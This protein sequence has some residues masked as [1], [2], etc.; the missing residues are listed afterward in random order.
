MI[1]KLS[2]TQRA[3]LLK[4][5]DGKEQ[6]ASRLKAGLGTL[7]S[8]ERRGMVVSR[9]PPGSMTY[10]HIYIHW[11]VTDTGRAALTERENAA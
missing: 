3:T 9:H 8:L 4:L 11:R 2:Q 1:T 10:P 6:N 7:Q 5:S